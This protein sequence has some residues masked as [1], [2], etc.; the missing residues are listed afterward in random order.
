MIKH[1]FNI[2]M[3]NLLRQKGLAFINVFGLSVGLACFMLF[4]LLAINEFS[5]DRF[6][7]NGDNIFRMYRWTVAMNGEKPGG[8]PYMPSPLGPALKQDL[9]D[10]VNYARYQ[11]AWDENFVKIDGTIKRA[12]V[13]YADPQF[14]TMFSFPVI[15]GSAEKALS[16]LNNIVI[17]RS[18]ARDLFGEENVIGR[19]IEIK[20]G[21]EFTPFIISSVMED[22]PANSSIHFGMLG[23]FS[24]MESTGSGKRGVN[25]W[26]RSAYT[27]FVELRPGSTLASD[28]RKLGDFRRKYYPNEEKELREEGFTWTA[29]EPP[30]SFRMQPLRSI[31]TDTRVWGLSVS[32]VDPRN[33][34]ILLSIAFGVLLIAC[35]NFTTLAIGRSASR[36]KEIGV[37]KVIGSN[38]KQ[39]VWQFLS[40]ALLLTI[41]SGI[42]GILLSRLL[43]P[44]FNRLSDRELQF[45]FSQYPEMA[46]LLAGLI[47][48]VGLLA[49]SYPALVL[50]RFKAVE[51]F[52]SKVRIGGSNLFTRSLV[53]LQFVLSIGL[54]ISTVIIL[55]QLSF[56]RDKDPGF[57]KN[58]VVMIDAGGTETKK[59]YPLFKQALAAEPSIAAVAGAELGLG[60]GTGFSRSG[61]EFEGKHK[62]VYEYY[63][64]P[65]YLGLL[66]IPLLAGRNFDPGIASDTITSV[67]IN[68]SM[69]NDFGWT[70][71]NAIGKELKGYMEKLT[72]VV[73]G[74]VRNIHY[75][76][77]SEKVEPQMFHQFHDY[78]PYTYL[79]RIQSGLTNEG[80][81]AIG[82]AWKA[83]EPVLPLKY[84]FLDESINNFYRSEQRWSSIVGWAGGISIFLACMGLFG[85]AALAAVNR[86]KEVGIR[87]VL[88]ASVANIAGLLS[89]D[90]L[91][92]VVIA[93]LIASPVAWY[94]MQKWLQDF[95]YR[96]S[97]GWAVF[98][99]SGIVAILVALVTV[100]F[101]TVKAALANP[102]KSL[103]TE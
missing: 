73:I 8:D 39:I 22:I 68:E 44:F 79:V 48:L 42:I 6:H 26:N 21:N 82:K 14:M 10:V 70:L 99:V 81:T 63:V 61:F 97:I 75:R 98:A 100:S 69:M 11:N 86:T 72:P 59:L 52:K 37:R 90:F 18:K 13:S 93:L 67:I 45:S 16:G 58:N 96:I 49:G 78:A 35:I 77:F 2:A 47:L 62:E 103:R 84:S 83:S 54:V 71:Q 23:N 38:K 76:P 25:N 64:D 101:Q 12:R 1:Y 9:P 66:N 55:Q 53:T 24:F 80:I 74:V 28:S 19:R 7:K 33:I 32:N 3:R 5:F 30:V 50:A 36:A 60:E 85:L 88:G 27:T 57:V 4:L 43:L 46:W 94:L 102:V 95:E 89:K 56:M 29:Q 65:S 31:H 15:Q 92:L 40:E 91:K 41:F 87:K 17:T 20:I 34:W 51:V